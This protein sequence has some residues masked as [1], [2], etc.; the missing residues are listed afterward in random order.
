[1]GCTYTSVEQSIDGLHDGYE[2]VRNVYIYTLDYAVLFLVNF[3]LITSRDAC[4][5]SK[6]Q[7]TVT[8]VTRALVLYGMYILHLLL[9]VF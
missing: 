2:I 4:A 9:C 7:V 1:M 3:Y 5:M 6:R 8:S